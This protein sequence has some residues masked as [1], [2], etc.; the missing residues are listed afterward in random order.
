MSDHVTLSERFLSK[1]SQ[2]ET[3]SGCLEWTGKPDRNGYGRL[4]FDG[5]ELYAHRTAFEL[6]SQVK[7]PR[8]MQVRHKCDNRRCVNPAHLELGTMQDNMMDKMSRQRQSK[9]ETHNSAKLKEGD[10]LRVRSLLKEGIAQKVIAKEYGVDQSLI[11][12]ISS[13]KIWRHL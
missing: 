8:G 1:S 2:S 3:S 11:S 4:G 13:G 12:L 10:I 9:G 6:Y 7:I 5:G